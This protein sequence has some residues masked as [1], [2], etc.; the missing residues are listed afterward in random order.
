MHTR[1]NT[2]LASGLLIF[3][4]LTACG[5]KKGDQSIPTPPMPEVSQAVPAPEVAKEK[6][7]Y[8][9]SGDR[10]RDPFMPA[11]QANNYQP[12][13]VFDPQRATVKG[14][15]FGDAYKSAVM[16]VG[17]SGSYFVKA[18]RIFDIM[19]K[20]VD[21]YSAK[22]FVDKVIVLG[23]ADNVFELKIKNTDDEE[24]KAL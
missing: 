12:D 24:E 15:I 16:T 19:G 20:P 5:K 7:V 9:Y 22:I 23:E 4:S 17:G 3:F 6:P 11:G 21:G 10:F 8:L 18:G 2:I 13:A 14:I 1:V